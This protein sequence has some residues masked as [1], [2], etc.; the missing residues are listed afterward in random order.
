MAGSSDKILIYE[1]NGTH[2]LPQQTITTNESTIYEIWMPEDMSGMVFGG[3]SNTFSIY[4][5]VN[6]TYELTHQ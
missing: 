6:G 1:S 2:Y 4:E 5:L 3:G